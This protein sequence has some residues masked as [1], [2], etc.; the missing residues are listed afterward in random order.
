MTSTPLHVVFG[1]GPVGRAVIAQVLHTGA[2]VRLVLRGT[3]PAAL[4]ARVEFVRGDA[5]DVTST[6][7]ACAGATFIYN[8]TNA[9]DYH[10]WP[11]QFPPLQRGILAGARA[12]G[13]VLTAVE[14]LYVYGPHR[15]EPLTETTPLNGRGLRSTTRVDMTRE[16]ERAHAQGDVRVVRARASD[17]IGPGVVESMAG[18]RLF[19]PIMRSAPSVSLFADPD[20]PHALTSVDDFARTLTAA[21]LEPRTHGLVIHAPSLAPTPRQLIAAIAAQASLP[22]PRTAALPRWSLPVVLPLLGFFAPSLRGLRE[23]ISMFY[24]P[25]TVD[26]GRAA[27]LLGLTATPLTKTIEL[28]LAWYRARGVGG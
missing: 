23:N 20:L 12:T 25:F 15:G 7:K 10:R 3:R 28:T 26:A 17:L 14:N 9:R 4:D 11:E 8:C 22:T 2:R 1:F 5:T 16:L 21:A 19:E 13:A 24:E 18:A 6:P 27:E